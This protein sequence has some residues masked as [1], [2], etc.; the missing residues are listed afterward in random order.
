MFDAK[1]CPVLDRPE[2]L[3]RIA[4]FCQQTFQI[5]PWFRGHGMDTWKL[6]P[7]VHRHT[8]DEPSEAQRRATERGLYLQFQRRAASRTASSPSSEDTPAWL[9]LMQHHGGPTC[10][11]DWSESLLVAC[12]FAVEDRKQ[13]DQDGMIWAL[14][15]GELN[16]IELKEAAC[17]MLS[18]F[19]PQVLDAYGDLHMQSRSPSQVVCALLPHEIHIRM[20]MQQS[21][22]TLHRGFVPLEQREQ[23]ERYLLGFRVPSN[24]KQVFRQALQAIGVRGTSLFPDLERLARELREDVK[25]K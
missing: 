10:L 15:P 17:G 1:T 23:S 5:S 11:L 8:E 20:L 16:R 13:H 12:F 22:F 7:S 25:F 2:E 18:P 21:V 19:D 24:R 3:F 6:T 4:S 9:S 14:H